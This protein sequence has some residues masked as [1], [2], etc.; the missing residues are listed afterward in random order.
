MTTLPYVLRPPT[1]APVPIVLSCPHVGTEI[2]PDIAATMTPLARRTPDTDWFVH[3]LYGFAPALGITL[4][5]A[6]F[7]RYVVDLNRDPAG[8]RLYADGRAETG[9]VPLQ[10]FALEPLYDGAA[11]DAA[12][13]RRRVDMYYAPYHATIEVALR[14]LRQRH[15]HVLFFDA[16]SIKRRV[17]S[18]RPEPFAD[19]ILGDQKGKTA[20]RELARTALDAL[21]NLSVAHNEPFQGGYLTRSFGRPA[22]GIHALQ[23]EMSQDL[24]MDED[25]VRR[26][27]AKEARVQAILRKL[28]TALARRVTELP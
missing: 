9:L 26:D 4:V 7:S 27:P 11:P 5:H 16:H 21:Q 1:S 25:A 20:D 3:D 8:A 18:I 17:P 12:E 19:V 24:Y 14:D 23:L 28:L 10:S 2:P 6:R 22:E 13:M 15:A